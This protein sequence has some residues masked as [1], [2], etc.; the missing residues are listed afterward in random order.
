MGICVADLSRKKVKTLDR[1]YKLYYWNLVTIAVFYALP[2]VQLVITYQA[3][4]PLS[5]PIVK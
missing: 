4:S 2:V 3:V 5:H 1:K